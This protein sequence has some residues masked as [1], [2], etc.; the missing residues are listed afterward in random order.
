MKKVKLSIESRSKR[1]RLIPRK[2]MLYAGE[3]LLATVYSYDIALSLMKHIMTS[4]HIEKI[5]LLAIY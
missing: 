1:D 4:Y 3:R 2:Y 5:N